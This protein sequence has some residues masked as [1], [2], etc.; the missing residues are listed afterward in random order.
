MLLG[1]Y[2][3]SLGTF[4]GYAILNAC[5][6]PIVYLLVVETAGHSLEE[7]G[8]WVEDHPKW[9]VHKDNLRAPLDVRSATLDGE[10]ASPSEEEPI[11]PSEAEQESS[12]DSSASITAPYEE[13]DLTSWYAR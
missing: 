5:F 11:V 12:G 9:L 10:N 3:S 4:L 8:T 1:G 13:V 7:I 6:V 2:K